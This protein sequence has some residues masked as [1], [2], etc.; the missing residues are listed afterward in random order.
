MNRRTR[1]AVAGITVGGA[2]L[3]LVSLGAEDLWLDECF[4]VRYA[5]LPLGE[6]V[7][8]LSADSTTPLLYLIS[9]LGLQLEPWLGLEAAVRLPSALAGIVAIPL[10]YAYVAGRVGQRAGVLAAAFAAV[11]AGSIHHAREAR[12][13]ALAVALAAGSL[14]LADLLRRSGRVRHAVAL[15]LTASALIHLHLFGGF[16]VV[17]IGLSLLVTKPPPRRALLSAA[18]VVIVVTAPIAWVLLQQLGMGFAGNVKH[19]TSLQTLESIVKYLSGTGEFA[20]EPLLLFLPLLALGVYGAWRRSRDELLV[21]AL[22][23]FVPLLLFRLVPSRLPVFARYFAYLLPLALLLSARGA[24]EL[25]RAVRAKRGRLA[26]G[27]VL[28][29]VAAALILASARPVRDVLEGSNVPHRQA[30]AWLDQRLGAD[31]RVL[32][33]SHGS[34]G[35]EGADA[36]RKTFGFYAPASLLDRC[37]DPYSLDSRAPSRPTLALVTLRARHGRALVETPPGALRLHRLLLAV[38]AGPPGESTREAV[39]RLAELDRAL[40]GHREDRWQGAFDR[41]TAD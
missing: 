36:F 18:A 24:L 38:P 8:A 16:L 22:A 29:A 35:P 25:A 26:A 12:F 34:R 2:A 41:W 9:W 30:I 40:P 27:R 31:G 15:G 20:R 3:R 5:R 1:L 19:P 28:A 39:R 37:V 7:P 6:L 11:H 32:I 21:A 33:H 17:A 23:L 13:Y 4:T 14:L 10:I